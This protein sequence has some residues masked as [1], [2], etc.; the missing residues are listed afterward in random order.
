MGAGKS[1]IGRLLS[2]E[3]DLEFVDSDREI[4]SRSGAS[5]PWIFDLEGEEGFRERESQAL[6]DLMQE[7]AKVIA[8][9]GG[10]IL[11]PGNRLLLQ[12]SGCV[13]YLKTS[14]E[15]QLIRTAKDKNR[16]LLQHAHPE[17]VL[18]KL[19]LERNPLYEATA[20]LTIDT[21]GLP[22]RAVVRAILRQLK[23]YRHNETQG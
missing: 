20:H 11:R 21:D 8:T 16:P 10:A 1:T 12:A 23:R 3:L 18:Q 6:E 22:P 5:I 13:V 2:E 14:V 15:Q 17:V 19:A 9:G 7:P 4:E